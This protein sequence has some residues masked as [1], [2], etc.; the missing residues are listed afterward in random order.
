MA[1]FLFQKDDIVWA[2]IRKYGIKWRKGVILDRFKKETDWPKH[3][4]LYNF[5]TMPHGNGFE[6][7]E[8]NIRLTDKLII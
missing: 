5:R 2:K 7:N 3:E 1:E 4:N 8:I 6:V